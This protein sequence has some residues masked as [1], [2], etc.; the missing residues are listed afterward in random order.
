MAQTITIDDILEA[1][2]ECE[3]QAVEGMT[4]REW[5]DMLGFGDVKTR[6]IVK[7]LVAVG[8]V[9]VHR[10]KAVGLDGVEYPVPVY[11]FVPEGDLS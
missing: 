4:M 1:L 10:K 2:G 3:Q 11:Q 7:D 8:R 6:R 9:R 5:K